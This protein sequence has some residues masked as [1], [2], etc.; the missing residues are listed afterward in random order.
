MTLKEFKNDFTNNIMKLGLDSKFLENPAFSRILGNFR[1]SMHELGALRNDEEYTVYAEDKGF[2]VNIGDRNFSVSILD[3]HTLEFL[4][5]GKNEQY[6]GADDFQ[7]EKRNIDQ[8]VI[9]VKEDGSIIVG[10]AKIL[11]ENPISNFKENGAVFVLSADSY[12]KFGVHYMSEERTIVAPGNVASASPRSE[13]ITSLNDAKTAWDR[14][15][16][17]KEFTKMERFG[18]DT[19]RYLRGKGDNKFPDEIIFSSVLPL[20]DQHGIVDMSVSLPEYPGEVKITSMTS[21]EVDKKIDA[22]V[23][24]ERLKVGLK[25]YTNAE[26]GRTAYSSSEDRTFISPNQAVSGRTR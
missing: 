10:S 13:I 15:W 18:F 20:N 5:V 16:K 25:R 6:R 14:N 7:W 4:V 11:Q 23:S 21:A 2:S 8:S 9:S 24:D 12:D 1:S 3:A 26:G 22:F 17:C 19:V